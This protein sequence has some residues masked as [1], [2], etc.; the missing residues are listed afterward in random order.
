M[1]LVFLR[2]QVGYMRARGFDVHVASSPGPELDA[3]GESE[4]VPTYAVPMARR[5]TPFGDVRALAELVRIMRRVRPDIVHAHTPKGGLLGMIA[6]TIAG[7]SVRVYHMR[8]LPMCTASGVR[9]WLLEATERLSCR[10]AHR[11]ICVSDSLRTVALDA[12][13]CPPHRITLLHAG[14]GNGVD[15]MGRFDPTRL[16]IDAREATRRRLS[17]PEDAVVVGFIGRLVRDKGI[18]ELS[19]AWGE[20][21]E[22]FPDAHLLLVG[23]FEPRDPVP[24]H[25]HAA[26]RDDPRVHLVG[27]DWNTPPLYAAM[28]VVALPTYREGFPNVPL[29]AA[30]MRLPVVAT[31]V[32][33]CVD[34]V[35]DGFTGTLV[36]ARDAAALAAALER[37]LQDP[38]LRQRHGDAGRAR[39]L[40]DFDQQ[41]IWRALHAEYDSLIIARLDRRRHPSAGGRAYRG[42]KRVLDMLV[43]GAG[44]VVLSPVLALVA[45][46]VRLRLGSPVLF[47]Q[48]RPGLHGEPFT[49]FKFRTMRDANDDDGNPLPDGIRLGAFGRFLRTTSLDELPELWNVLRGDMSLVGP[50]PLLME[51][52]PL[53]RPE[54]ARRHDVPPGLTGWAQVH[55]RNAVTWGERLALDEW[56]VDHRSVRLDLEILLRT[57]GTV[58]TRHGITQP[59]EATMERFSG[60]AL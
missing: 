13:L 41:T 24:A 18:V 30:A 14:S 20:A 8:G 48:Q 53:Y 28:D 10:L 57:V 44:L 11:V 23:P 17:I 54:Q 35:A 47:R 59:G 26:L 21:R 34:A 1:S 50:R 27:E 55:G 19:S 4:E 42:V 56:Y 22:R 9:R 29:E 7:V 31:R 12:G 15:A 58:F 5:I 38:A 39:A 25:V 16:C 60:S 46:A 45:L 3:F 37:Y 43:A 33:G 2:G 36:P 6:A 40:R 49:L 51:Y 32:P 52:V